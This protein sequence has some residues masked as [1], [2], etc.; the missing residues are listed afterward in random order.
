MQGEAAF[1]WGNPRL[2]KEIGSIRPI[3]SMGRSAPVEVR[4]ETVVVR[5]SRTAKAF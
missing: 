4:R 3:L 1:L 5:N 2:C